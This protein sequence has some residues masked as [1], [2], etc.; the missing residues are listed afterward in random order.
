MRTPG[1]VD[2]RTFV[3]QT[4]AA[5]VGLG[6]LARDSAWSAAATAPGTASPGLAKRTLGR[7]GLEVTDIS[8]GGIQIQQERLLDMAIDR[9]INLVHTSPGY[10]G[11]K[12]I[13]LFGQVM[14]RRRQE[15][16]LALKTSPVGGIDEQLRILNTDHVDI[17]VPPLHSVEAMNNPELPGAYEKLRK[18]GKIRFSGYACHKNIAAVMSRSVDLGFYDVMLIAYNLGNRADLDPILLRAKTEQNMGFMAM[19]AAKDIEAGAHGPAFA[20]LLQNPRVDTLLVGMATFDQVKQNV[21]FSGKQTGFLD[22]L[23]LLD[24]A[25]LPATACALCGAC[26]G[27]CPRGVATANIL[28]CGIY[29]QRGETGLARTTYRELP[30]AQSMAG[31]DGCGLCDAACPRQR[32]VSRELRALHTALA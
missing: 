15:V 4:A 24:Y 8:F 28:R 16:L 30:A 26:E 32:Q 21:T 23:Q 2:R 14:K 10:G 19:K 20:S 31:C 9:G 11:G 12:S 18:E 1:N 7:T 13:Q 22:R 3:R 6:L 29:A 17:L 27:V 5:S 25:H